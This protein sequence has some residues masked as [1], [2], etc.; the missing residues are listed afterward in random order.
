MRNT[1]RCYA[2]CPSCLQKLE[3][4]IDQ[5]KLA[6]LQSAQRVGG[7]GAPRRKA[8]KKPKGA[9]AGG[10]DP[11][12]QAAM[13]KLAVQPLTGIEEVNMFKADGNVLHIDAPKGMFR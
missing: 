1:K 8:V 11:K 2:Y 7:K 3:M 4:P 10:D 13:K 6:K 9:V 12:L 5:E